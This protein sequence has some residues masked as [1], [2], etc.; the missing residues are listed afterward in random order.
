MQVLDHSIKLPRGV[1]LVAQIFASIADDGFALYSKVVHQKQRSSIEWLFCPQ[2][3]DTGWV[4]VPLVLSFEIGDL[5]AF[6][7][8]RGHSGCDGTR[9]CYLSRRTCRTGLRWFPSQIVST[10]PETT[11][12]AAEKGG[13]LVS[14]RCL[15]RPE[16][17][18]PS[19]WSVG[20]SVSVVLL[21][22]IAAYFRYKH[23]RS[24]L[25]PLRRWLII[26]AWCIRFGRSWPNCLQVWTS[27]PGFHFCVQEFLVHI[28]KE[29]SMPFKYFRWK[30]FVFFCIVLSFMGWLFISVRAYT[31]IWSWVVL[32]CGTRLKL[33]GECWLLRLLLYASLAW[34]VCCLPCAPF[35]CHLFL[36]NQLGF[37]FLNIIVRC[38]R[39]ACYTG[40]LLANILVGWYMWVVG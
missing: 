18:S 21:L 22:L 12:F 24:V 8:N 31:N 25:L 32:D 39:R 3:F 40:A 34:G 29:N 14:C 23:R 6:R 17:G 13:L 35:E 4:L 9:R 11:L 20:S 37:Q 38:V 2:C 33:E 30:W 16:V 28:Q 19:F 5:L 36:L 15:N 26:L 10:V 27:R 1:S 7:G